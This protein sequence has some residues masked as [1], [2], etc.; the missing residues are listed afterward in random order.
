MSAQIG[1][2]GRRGVAR[3][4]IELTEAD[5]IIELRDDEELFARRDGYG[6]SSAIEQ[7]ASDHQPKPSGHEATDLRETEIHQRF[8]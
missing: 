3:R 4:S 5:L 2:G 8:A 1:R 6:L 7:C